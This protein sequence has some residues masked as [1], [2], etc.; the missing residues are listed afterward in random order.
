[1]LLMSTWGT[2]KKASILKGSANWN[3]IGEGASS[4]RKITL[5]IM[6]QFL[7]LG[8]PKVQGPRT[9]LSSLVLPWE[10]NS[11]RVYPLFR[12]R[13]NNSDRVITPES[14]PKFT[15]NKNIM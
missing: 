14:V 5:E 11:F 12:R 4:Q 6:A 9:F 10:A 15:I 7:L 3:S 1:M 2:M 8:I 13:Q